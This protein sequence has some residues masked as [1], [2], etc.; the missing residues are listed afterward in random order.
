ME[1]GRARRASHLTEV[2]LRP[3]TRA[4]LFALCTAFLFAGSAAT[5]QD[6][7][8]LFGSMC[9]GCHNDKD[10]PK[11]LVYNAAGNVSFIETENAFGMG[12]AG[13]LVDHTAIAAYLD[14]T[15]PTIKLKPIAY[16]SPGTFMTLGDIVVSGAQ[17]HA[18]WRIIDKIETVAPPTKGTVAYQFKNGFGEPSYVTYTPFPGQSGFDSWTYQGIGSKGTTTIRTATVNIANADGTF[19]P[20][21]VSTLTAVEYHHAAWDHFFVTAIPQEIS[22][23]DSGAFAGWARTGLQFNVYPLDAAATSSSYVCRFFSTSFAPRSSHYYSPEPGCGQLMTNT[24]W[25]LEGQ[26][27]NLVASPAGSCPAGTTPLYR[28]YNNGAGA[29]PNHRYTIDASVR[30]QMI[31]AGWTAEGNGPNTVFMCAPL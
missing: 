26:V 31:A 13:S 17:M 15:K 5:A 1:H 20:P 24:N 9:S 12:A 18:S 14:A 11:G 25:Q 29:A 3:V 28:L 2:S 23:L 22:S 8:A 10:H 4:I 19:P 7:A 16:N 30:D 27:F 6:G 21:P